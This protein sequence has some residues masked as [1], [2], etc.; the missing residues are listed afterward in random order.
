MHRPRFVL[1]KKG[2]LRETTT[3]QAGDRVTVD[4][5][6][7]L[8][9]IK[10][11]RDRI[12]LEVERTDAGQPYAP[13]SLRLSGL[14]HNVCAVDPYNIMALIA[15]ARCLHFVFIENKKGVETYELKNG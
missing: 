4:R 6:N 15:A 9:K 13:R 12:M 3:L 14:Q 7:G 11:G 1:V 2:G 8:T 5:N 10:R